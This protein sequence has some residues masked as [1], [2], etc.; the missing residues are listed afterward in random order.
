MF[1][2]DGQKPARI[3]ASLVHK[4]GKEKIMVKQIGHCPRRQKKYML[5]KIN[6]FPDGQ[7]RSV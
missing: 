6:I 1:R 3:N 5:F 2:P 4:K 7:G